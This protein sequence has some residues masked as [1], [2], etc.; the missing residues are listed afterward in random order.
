MTGRSKVIRYWDW[1]S[2]ES[3]GQSLNDRLAERSGG[4]VQPCLLWR[5]ERRV[6]R[7]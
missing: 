7:R 6:A 2:A 3:A 1:V 5:L 4:F